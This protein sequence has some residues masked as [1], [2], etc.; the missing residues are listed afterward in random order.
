MFLEVSLIRKPY[1]TSQS[2]GMVSKFTH[3]FLQIKKHYLY[4]TNSVCKNDCSIARE[5]KMAKYGTNWK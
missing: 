2:Q 1:N 3:F 5:E 4:I